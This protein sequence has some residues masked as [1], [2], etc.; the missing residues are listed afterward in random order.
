MS[1]QDGQSR[2]PMLVASIGQR[3][4]PQGL[5]SRGG[6]W[7]R[8]CSCGLLSAH[9]TTMYRPARRQQLQGHAN[10]GADDERVAS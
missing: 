8:L 7:D 2:V 10:L 6:W 9:H 4:E 1:T 5:A 3:C